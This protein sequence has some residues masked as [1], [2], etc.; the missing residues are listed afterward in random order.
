[1]SPEMR[2]IGSASTW[3]NLA[4][5][6]AGDGAHGA[7]ARSQIEHDIAARLRAAN[8]HVALGGLVQ[9]LRSVDDRAGDQ[10]ALAVV[11][12]AASAR[13]THRDVARL[14]QFQ[15]ALIR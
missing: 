15:D 2:K 4:D 11:A 3:G 1:M 7:M 14:G 9:R 6:A 8:E 13:P 10:P 5:P 12:N